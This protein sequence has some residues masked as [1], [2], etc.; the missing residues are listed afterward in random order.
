MEKDLKNRLKEVAVEHFNRNGYHGTTIRNI[1]K[2]VGC[3]LPMVYYYYSSKKDLFHEIIKN[4]YFD[5]LQ[6]LV[7]QINESNIIEYYTQYVAQMNHLSD[8]DRKIYRLGIKVFLSF[9]GDDELMELM[10]EWD[11][12][13]LPRHYQTIMPHLKDI[14]NWVAVVRTLIH[15]MENLIE[16]IVVK[17]QNMTEEQI[18]EELTIVLENHI[19]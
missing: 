7:E 8:Y 11:K 13:I 3:S 1:A 9:D 15:L 4:D 12:S 14:R 10:E 16:S 6:R 18:R 2:D 17:N 19:E 5:L